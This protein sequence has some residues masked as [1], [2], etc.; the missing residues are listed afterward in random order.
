MHGSRCT[1]PASSRRWTEGPGQ[2]LFAVRSRVWA[3][4]PSSQ[5]RIPPAPGYIRQCLAKWLRTKANDIFPVTVITPT[6]QNLLLLVLVLSVLLPL[7]FCPFIY[8]VPLILFPLSPMLIKECRLKRFPDQLWP[9]KKLAGW[10]NCFYF[11]HVASSSCSVNNSL[12][13][14]RATGSAE[15]CPKCLWAKR[16]VNLWSHTPFTLI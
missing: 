1:K 3:E 7:V 8:I 14:L 6:S 5:W 11:P 10:Q 15:A 12:L 4:Q 9:E 13:R 2:M 16:R